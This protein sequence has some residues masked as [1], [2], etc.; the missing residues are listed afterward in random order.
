MEPGKLFIRC[1]TPECP[2]IPSSEGVRRGDVLGPLRFCI[3]LKPAVERAMARF[4]VE[5]PDLRIELFAHMDNVWV[6]FR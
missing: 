3:G 1:N 5:H 4:D 2:V 6:T